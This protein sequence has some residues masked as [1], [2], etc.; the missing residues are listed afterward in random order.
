MNPQDAELEEAVLGACLVESKAITLIAGTLRPEMF[1]QETNRE[2]Y[3]ALQSMYDAGLRVDIITVKEELAKR[4]KLDLIGGPYTLARISGRMASSVHLEYHVKIL[5]QKY[6]R[7]EMIRGLQE[8]LAASADET[9]DIADTI[10]NTHHLLDRVENEC[11]ATEHLRSM[12][13]LMED[14]IQQV[15]HRVATSKNGVTGV[16]TGL[17]DLDRLTAGWQSGDLIVC[18]ARPAVGKTAFALHLARSAA[19]A[20]HHVLV[21]SLEMNGER[22]GDRWLLAATTDV[23]SSH[24]RTGQLDPGELRRVHEA[25]TELAHLPIHIDDNPSVSIDYVRFSAKLLQSKGLCD[26]IIIDYLQLCDMKADRSNRN[27]EQEVAQVSRKAKMLAKELNVPVIL[28]SQLNRDS[29]GR[30]D[31]RPALSDLR[32][33]GAIEQDADIVLLLH[34]PALYGRVTDRKTSYPTEGLGIAIVAKNRNGETGEVYFSHNKSLTK[35]GDYTPGDL[36][37]NQHAK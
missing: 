2:I 30:P 10:V 28:L 27:R 1:Y 17:T 26:A 25:S 32:E 14:T 34:R 37:M 12:E 23:D 5:K 13:Q 35:I 36:W 21:Y 8:L 18:G 31:N 16:P 19:S 9:I 15:E 11:G 22:L 6:I 7:R 24:L 29:E 3:A 33:S 20:G 4:G